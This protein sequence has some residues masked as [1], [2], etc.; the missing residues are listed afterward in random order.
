MKLKQ[1]IQTKKALFCFLLISLFINFKTKPFLQIKINNDNSNRNA[2]I[3]EKDNLRFNF[4]NGQSF[5][6][7]KFNKVK[8]CY[9]IQ[10]FDLNSNQILPSDLSLHYNL[11]ILCIL[12]LNSTINIY[13]LPVIKEDKYFKCVEF[14]NLN[15][16]IKIGVIIYEATENNKI[17][18][19]YFTYF[20]GENTFNYKNQ[21]DSIFD[22]NK[23][24]YKYSLLLSQIQNQNSLIETKKLKSLYVSKPKCI[25]KRNYAEKQNHWY[26]VNLFNE[27]FCLCK[28]FNCLRSLKI[29]GKCKYYFYIYLIDT[30]RNVYKK[31][32][33]L[34][35]DFI[36]KKFSSD[37]VYPI[38][39]EMINLNINAH[40]LTEKKEIYDKYCQNRK[41]C[42]TIILV[43]ANNYKIN[44][45]FLEKYL[46]LILKLRQVHSSVGVNINFINNL[47]FNIDY[48]T[49]V[50]IGHGVSYFKYYLYKKYYGPQNFDKL[51]IPNSE[52]LISVTLK[53]GWKEEN[54]IKFNLPRWDKYNFVT[55]YDKK[56]SNIDPNSIFIMF[57]WRE[58]KRG[59]KISLDYLNNIVNLINH[60]KLINNL[61]K[62]KLT[63]Y[64]T[65]HH[66]VLKYKR[67]F[68]ITKNIR[69]ILENDISECLS[70]T[71]LVVT[72]FSSIIFDM[73]YRRKPYIIYIPDSNDS[74]IYN[75]Y[76]ERCYK[77]INNFKN[78][79]FKFENVYCDINSTLDKIN[80][81]IDNRFKLEH[82]INKFYDE[83]N[84]KNGTIIKEFI[85]YILKL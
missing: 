16:Y 48:I 83:F 26:F 4:Y 79:E 13:S 74:N 58:I 84:F 15:E 64:F 62:Y 20:F 19:N 54:L 18:K 43:K 57:T 69:Y 10:V 59:R 82:K 24:N 22:Y 30:N 60:E 34:L 38:F 37:D 33:F 6:S 1:N 7:N 85:R 45:D 12:N 5:Y 11:H 77:I 28:G 68:K 8:I 71:N 27:Y 36:L 9:R 51:L 70:K 78:N 49:Y 50:C 32:D 47:F 3:F 29:Y 73:I 75:I 53:F 42:D 80:Y 66:K 61:L 44:H 46:T 65:L 63:L 56:N 2:N 52:K 31:T 35:M 17:N 76:R 41:N 25:L 21:F 23:I 55:E 72:D 14:S 67:K 81:Y 39:E 40:Y